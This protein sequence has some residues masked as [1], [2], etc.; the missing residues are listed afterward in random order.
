MPLVEAD[1]D[2]IPSDSQHICNGEERAKL[3]VVGG[4]RS[5]IFLGTPVVPGSDSVTRWTPDPLAPDDILDIECATIV[6]DP[7]GD[8]AT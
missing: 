3:P 2:V 4:D 5:T 6:H 1:V 8:L 7:L